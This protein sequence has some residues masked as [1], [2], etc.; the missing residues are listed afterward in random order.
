[1]NVI[2]QWDSRSVASAFTSLRDEADR[3][4]I[5]DGKGDELTKSR[6][7]STKQQ[8]FSALACY[9]QHRYQVALNRLSADRLRDQLLLKVHFGAIR[10]FSKLKDRKMAA[11]RTVNQYLHDKRA[12]R[13]ISV[14]RDNLAQIRTKEQNLR[15]AC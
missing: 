13:L 2:G 10:R 4:L 14:L 11:I 1:M 5:M 6:L 9:K 12:R 15:T 7:V 3:V 8:V